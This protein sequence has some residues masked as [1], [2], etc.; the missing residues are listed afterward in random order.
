MQKKSSPREAYGRVLVELGASC[1]EL[2]VLDADLSPST[3][4]NEFAKSYPERFFNMGIAE[5]NM[6]GTAAGFAL[7]LFLF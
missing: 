3:K 2:V 7:D 1:P 6:M 4:T 5:Q